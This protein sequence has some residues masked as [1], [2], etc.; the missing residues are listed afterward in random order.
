MINKNNLLSVSDRWVEGGGGGDG[1]NE[2]L[3]NC[4]F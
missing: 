1:S 3:K 2:K 4:R